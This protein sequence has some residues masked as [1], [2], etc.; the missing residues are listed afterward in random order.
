MPIYVGT[1]ASL[2]VVFA[3][4]YGYPFDDNE[5]WAREEIRRRR[6]AELGK[7]EE[8]L[9]KRREM[10][11]KYSES[12]APVFQQIKLE[13]VTKHSAWLQT[14]FDKI[15]EAKTLSMML[16][17][18]GKASPDPLQEFVVVEEASLIS[19]NLKVR[20]E[21]NK[22]VDL[23]HYLLFCSERDLLD[24]QKI[25]LSLASDL[26][27][28]NSLRQ[29]LQ[30]GVSPSLSLQNEKLSEEEKERILF[31]HSIPSQ[32]HSLFNARVSSSQKVLKP[33]SI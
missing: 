14:E 13:Q 1:A 24:S 21:R 15:V 30:L 19:N 26:L 8:E 12:S 32:F 5:E 3:F 9:N 28:N 18:Q 16:T 4:L 20:E 6:S 31:Q 22:E 17:L 23:L 29:D 10:I 25:N 11:K 7:T 2:F 33:F 27:S